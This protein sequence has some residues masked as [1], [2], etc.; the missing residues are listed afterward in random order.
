MGYALPS[1]IAEG[2]HQ[3]LYARSYIVSDM[4]L[5][6]R[7]VFVTADCGMGSQI[8]KL[9]VVKKLKE[10]YGDSMYDY[11]FILGGLSYPIILNEVGFI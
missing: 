10:I 1:Q 6:S 7:V 3:R 4:N 8:I 2:L 5:T 11:C 9:E